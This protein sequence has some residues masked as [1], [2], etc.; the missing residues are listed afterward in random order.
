MQP[1]V[2]PSSISWR[3]PGPRGYIALGLV[4]IG[5]Y[6]TVSML[7]PW[8]GAMLV[9]DE[10]A[11]ADAFDAERQRAQHDEDM[12]S[13]V[14]VVQGRSPFFI[15]PAPIVEQPVVE[16]EE[17]DEDDTPVTP[18]RYGGPDIVAAMNGRIW[19]DNN[20]IIPLGEEV[21]GVTLVSL[22]NV[23]WSV[24]V[25]WRGAEFDVD[26][27]ENTTSGFLTPDRDGE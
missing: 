14:A 3:T 18:S 13:W 15:P 26:I 25:G 1:P 5:L 6:A 17:D 16:V 12:E 23:P 8:V 9:S 7:I 21:S 2:E 20:T 10:V 22:D 11:K 24:R 4:L 27:F 19:L